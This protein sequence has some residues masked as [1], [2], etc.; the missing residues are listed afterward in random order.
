MLANNNH[1]YR[2]RDVCTDGPVKGCTDGPVKGCTERPMKVPPLSAGVSCRVPQSMNDSETV[3]LIGGGHAF[4]KT[5]GG[6]RW[7]ATSSGFLALWC[8]TISC[9]VPWPC[10]RPVP[11]LARLS[12]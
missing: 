3:A 10:T 2:G 12:Y 11:S 9:T 1:I 4:G 7:V 8:H 5:H 6:S